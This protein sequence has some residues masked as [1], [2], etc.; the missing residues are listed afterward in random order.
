MNQCTTAMH[1]PLYCVIFPRPIIHIPLMTEFWRTADR[2]LDFV[3]PIRKSQSVK[4]D[5]NDW[6]G[7]VH[8]RDESHIQ[9]KAT[10]NIGSLMPVLKPFKRMIH[11]PVSHRLMWLSSAPA[12]AFVVKQVSS[13]LASPILPAV[14]TVFASTTTRTT[15]LGFVAQ[16]GSSLLMMMSIKGLGSHETSKRG[17]VLGIAGVSAAVLTVVLTNWVTPAGIASQFF[18]F[19]PVAAVGQL[20]GITVA[21]SVQMDQM[22]ELVASFHSLTGLA[23]VLVGLSAQFGHNSMSVAKMIETFLGVA[24]GAATFSGSVAAALKLHG[25]IPGG[26]VGLSSRWYINAIAG[27]GLGAQL[28]AYIAFPSWRVLSLC[29]NT[30]LSLVLGT[31]L[32]LPIGGADIPIVISLLNSLSGLATSATGFSLD[33]SLLVMSGALIASSGAILSDIMCKGIN[34]SLVSVLVGGFGVDPSS[35]GAIAPGDSVTEITSVTVQQMVSK[36]QQAKR[37]LIIPGYGMA[38]ARC[39]S[40]V[41]EIFNELS[42]RGVEVVFGIHPVAG[43]LPGHMNV[44]LSEAGIPYDVVKEMEDVNAEMKS[45]DV[46]IVLGAND[47]VNPATATDPS[48]P[49]FGMP[50]IEC[51]ESKSVVVMKRSMNTG[52]SG[53][54]NPL[55]YRENTSMLFGDAKDT[56]DKLHILI[57]ESDLSEWPYEGA[58][59]SASGGMVRR[60]ITPVAPD[61]SRLP[62]AKLVIGALP[63]SSS[64][65]EKRIPISPKV[66][67]KLRQLGFGVLVPSGIGFECGW[68][69]AWFEQHGAKI[70]NS[71]KQVIEQSDIVLKVTPLTNEQLAVL[72]PPEGI[73]RKQVLITSFPTTEAVVEELLPKLTSRQMTTFNLTL[74]PRISRAQSMDIMSSMANLAGYKAVINA[75]HRLGKLSRSSVTA[76]G[77]IPAARVFVIGCGVAGL[78]A[79][80]TAHALGA[81]VLA[82]DVRPAT[83]EQVESI[84][85]KFI[86]V[87][88]EVAPV[89]R[90]GYATEVSASFAERQKQL[91]REYTANADIVITTAMVPGRPAPKLVSADMV[92]QMRPGSIIVDL[93]APSGGNCELTNPDEIVVDGASRVVIDG[94]CNY[95]GE[96][97]QLSSELFSQN[98]FAFIEN[99]CGKSKSVDGLI[100]REQGRFD[101]SDVIVRQ[102]IVVNESTVM[103]PPPAMEIQTPQPQRPP[104]QVP[105]AHLASTS[106]KYSEEILLVAG[107]AALGALGLTA[108]MRTVRLVGDFVLSCVIGHFTVSSVTPALHT[109]LISVTNALSG[110]IVVGGMLEMG[111][112]VSPQSMCALSA[113]LVSL[114]NVSGGF[115]VTDRMLSMFKSINNRN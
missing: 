68:S 21:K 26:P 45:F 65:K 59:T 12:T 82:T 41:C 66:V 38:V 49:I 83:K 9:D 39:Q 85:A 72:P 99:L 5:W 20:I 16:L 98:C 11:D 74:V 24:V 18:W 17:N 47:I 108:D 71:D 70:V 84:G 29:G 55:F 44:I 69:D 107:A 14:A 94:T 32:V 57:A 112:G 51:W 48:S 93:A 46:A 90:G 60:E 63:D 101:L 8:V 100:E 95:A 104:V 2:I 3:A 76:G 61:L 80:A 105:I 113:V 22:P 102:S 42:K 92:K 58:K 106:G 31:M 4:P 110:I 111:P 40:G 77:N 25:I 96:L 87:T 75:F 54:D 28:W 43:R 86:T 37:V 114:I 56:V 67:L 103:Y 53:V 91:Y 30:A 15:P 7:E 34:R 27:L 78:S 23:A 19:L 109:P 79:I 97:I 52:Y 88:D 62:E 50:A 64:S 35:P 36:L 33:N 1:E 6:F 115:A 10:S 81:T 89:E 73:E 13:L